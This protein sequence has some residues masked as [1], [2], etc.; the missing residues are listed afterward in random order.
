MQPAVLFA[1]ETKHDWSLKSVMNLLWR[2]FKYRNALVCWSWQQEGHFQLITNSC[3]KTLL[4]GYRKFYVYITPRRMHCVLCLK[5]LLKFEVN[6][7]KNILN[8]IALQCLS[9]FASAFVSTKPKLCIFLILGRTM[10]VLWRAALV[11]SK[12]LFQSSSHLYLLITAYC[13]RKW[14]ILITRLG[15]LS[16]SRWEKAFHHRD[17][18]P[19]HG[20]LI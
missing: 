5:F 12:R 18:S 13:N 6:T 19:I 2:N 8:I 4:S 17:M 9:N 3:W 14:G 1:L 20:D 7:L 10:A 11:C 16:S 15:Y